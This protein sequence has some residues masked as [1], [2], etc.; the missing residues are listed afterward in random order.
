[1]LFS[2]VFTVLELICHI[3]QASQLISNVCVHCMFTVGNQHLCLDKA[4]FENILNVVAVAQVHSTYLACEGSRVQAQ[5]GPK[6]CLN[7]NWLLWD[8]RRRKEMSSRIYTKYQMV[9]NWKKHQNSV[10]KL[11]SQNQKFY[12]WYPWPVILTVSLKKKKKT[13]YL[14]KQKLDGTESILKAIQQKE[15]S[16]T[17]WYN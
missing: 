9:Q 11:W 7:M 15:V 10:A 12:V 16:Y 3:S 13:W 4:F 5:T 1:M 2:I 17:L 14:L 8:K 6:I